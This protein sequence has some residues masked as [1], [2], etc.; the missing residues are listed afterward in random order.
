MTTD[1]LD[2]RA[3]EGCPHLC[4][5][6]GS[7]DAF[8]DEKIKGLVLKPCPRFKEH[9]RT[10][11]LLR[12]EQARERARVLDAVLSARPDCDDIHDCLDMLRTWA[13]KIEALRA[14]EETPE[15]TP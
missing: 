5:A 1:D 10:A 6:N 3:R 2:A 11:T 12:A 8:S 15:V 7:V 13:T 14:H 9:Q 4:D